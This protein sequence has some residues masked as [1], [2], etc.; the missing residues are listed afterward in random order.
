MNIANA[1][2]PSLSNRWL[3]W[4][5]K[6]NTVFIHKSGTKY[7]NTLIRIH[8]VY[9]QIILNDNTLSKTLFI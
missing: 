2:V 4:T 7:K 3:I 6:K 8:T 9:T 1:T 5:N